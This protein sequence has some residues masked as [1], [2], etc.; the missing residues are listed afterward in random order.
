MRLVHL[1]WTMVRPAGLSVN[2]RV[3]DYETTA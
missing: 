2:E 1:E 3:T